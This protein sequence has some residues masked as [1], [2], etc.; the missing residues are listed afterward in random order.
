M[1]NFSCEKGKFKRDEEKKKW[2]GKKKRRK[3]GKISEEFMDG[4]SFD[5][6]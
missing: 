4:A 1:Y 6:Q 3:S 2:T 5:F